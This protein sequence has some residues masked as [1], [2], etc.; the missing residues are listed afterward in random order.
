MIT[1][2][3]GDVVSVHW[4]G[5]LLAPTSETFTFVLSGDEGFRMFLNGVL[6]IDR[7]DTCCDVM[8]ASAYLEAG[9]Y[10][11]FILQYK[12]MSS[13]A[14][15]KVEWYSS[16]TRQEVIPATQ[17]FYSQR[18]NDLVYQVPVIQGPTIPSQSTIA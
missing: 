17:L 8:T 6:L 18:V 7:W 13:E 16:S 3:A 5:K 4:Y 1:P 14:N 12:E 2:E 10:Y 9:S 15:F 11:D